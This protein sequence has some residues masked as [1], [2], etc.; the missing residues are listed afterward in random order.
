MTCT[1]CPRTHPPRAPSNPPQ[2]GHL[3]GRLLPKAAA[4]AHGGPAARRL[5]RGSDPNS[6]RLTP[7]D[8]LTFLLQNTYM[9]STQKLPTCVV[10]VEKPLAEDV[11]LSIERELN[12]PVSI[13]IAVN[14]ALM[15]YMQNLSTL[16][17][18]RD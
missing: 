10:R 13:S 6:D 11:R 5:T 9:K 18:A 8:I 2:R 14:K 15:E 1:E 7:L 17:S 12:V 3:F 16:T 4:P